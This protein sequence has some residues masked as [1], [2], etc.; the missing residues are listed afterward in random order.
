MNKS[1]KK[2]DPIQIEVSAYGK[3]SVHR[4]QADADGV[5]AEYFRFGTAHWFPESEDTNEP[6]T[7]KI[8]WSDEYMPLPKI[9]VIRQTTSLS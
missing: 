2:G 8:A 1:V 3:T 6:E 5:V 9:Q 4:Y 7:H